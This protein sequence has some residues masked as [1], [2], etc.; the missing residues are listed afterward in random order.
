MAG[1]GEAPREQE[2]TLLLVDDDKPFLTRLG[3]AME[4]R[5]FTVELASSVAEGLAMVRRQP[6]NFAVVDMRLEDG[7]GLDV[8]SAL[9]EA[10]PNARAVVL[11]GYGNIAT[12]VSAVKMGA[13]D[14]LAKPADADMVEKSLMQGDDGR[15]GLPENP[16]S[17]D[18]VRWE[19]IQR[20]YEMCD[21][22]VSE[23]ARRLNM[24]RRTLQRILAKRAPR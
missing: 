24:H 21:R 19:H 11:T 4:T 22:N 1:D 7:N 20:V 17:A 13:T 6:P 23:T 3:R 2:R 10:R 14:Y 16:M 12:A 18:R 5:G 9:R 8:V 15:T